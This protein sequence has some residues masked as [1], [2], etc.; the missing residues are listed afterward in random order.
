MKLATNSGWWTDAAVLSG[1][2]GKPT[3]RRQGVR[4]NMKGVGCTRI[5]TVFL[6]KAAVA[7]FSSMQYHYC[8]P[9]QGPDHVCLQ[10]DLKLFSNSAI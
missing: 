5:D 1:M 8:L 7:L 3:F 10:V 9:G 2:S 6:N 4:Q